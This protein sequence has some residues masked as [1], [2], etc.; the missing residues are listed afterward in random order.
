[1]NKINDS[2]IEMNQ[3]FF[4]HIA[5]PFRPL[6][7]WYFCDNQSDAN[8]C[9]E[10]ALAGVKRATTTSLLWLEQSKAEPMPKV[11]DV[12]IV[13]DWHGKAV[14]VIETIAVAIRSFREIDSDYAYLEGE[15][16]K[17]L[18]YWQDV[19]WAYYQRELLDYDMQPSLDMPLVCEEFCCVFPKS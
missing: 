8:E 9:A 11:G 2:V 13:T 19:H 3:A 18:S 1:M 6:P 12:N 7:A 14:C 10:L 17:S 5:K 15:G 16:D 4:K